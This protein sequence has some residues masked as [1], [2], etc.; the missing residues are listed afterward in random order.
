MMLMPLIMTGQEEFS[1][2]S[3]CFDEKTTGFRVLSAW[4]Y[5]S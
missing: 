3:S 2:S 4:V 5:G 1:F